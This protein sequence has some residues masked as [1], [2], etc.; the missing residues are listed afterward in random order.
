MVTITQDLM[1]IK[2]NPGMKVIRCKNTIMVNI[3]DGSRG[4]MATVITTVMGR[5]MVVEMTMVII[6]AMIM[7]TAIT[8]AMII[9]MAFIKA[10]VM[11]MEI[12]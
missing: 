11:K 1:E 9:V 12:I 7:V 10:I 6:M 8:M 2:I 3:M 5:V 4:I